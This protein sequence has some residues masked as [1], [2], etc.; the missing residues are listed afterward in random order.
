MRKFKTNDEIVL[1]H[2]FDEIPVSSSDRIEASIDNNSLDT[3]F[4]DCT[5]LSGIAFRGLPY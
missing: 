4:T 2:C 5:R 1:F 3:F